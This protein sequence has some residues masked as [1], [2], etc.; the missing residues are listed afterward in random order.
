MKPARQL[1]RRLR[2]L[3]TLHEAVSAMKSLSAHHFRLCRNALAPAR[4]YR[5]QVERAA[6]EAGL[7]QPPPAPSATGLLVVAS[8]LGLC[9]DYNAR[10]RALLLRER[11]AAPPG[12]TYC[13]GRRA[14]AGLARAGV[15]VTRLYPSP[16]SLDGVSSTLLSLAQDLLDDHVRGAFGPLYVV[17]ARFEGVGRF[18]AVRTQVLPIAPA[19]AQS[20]LRPTAYQSERHLFAVAVRELLYITLYELLLDALAAE[21]GMRLLASESARNWLQKSAGGVQRQLAASRREATTQ[22]VLDIVA[23]PARLRTREGRG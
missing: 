17:S 5:T 13:I 20:P 1:E 23:A 12:P 14:H 6:L 21:H 19:G 11:A 15:E 3:N 4:A 16:A 7:H 9:A 18:E 2:T 10:L 22:E 8:D